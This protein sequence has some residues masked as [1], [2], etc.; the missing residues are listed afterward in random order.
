[1]RQYHD[2][3]RHV[4]ATGNRKENR[5]GVDTISTFG[6]YYE[7]DLREGFPLL[8]TKKMPWRSIVIELLWFLSGTNRSGFLDR[9]GVTFWKPW[10]N[11]PGNPLDEVYG[12]PPDGVTVN[13]AY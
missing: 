5:T 3:I 6:Y 2:L 4:L 7:H 9:H 11:P 12:T 1:M 10:Y 8:T 13:A